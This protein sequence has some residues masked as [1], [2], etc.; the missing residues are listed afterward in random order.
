[1]LDDDVQNRDDEVLNFAFDFKGF[2][3]KLLEYWKVIILCVLLGLLLAYLI[4][5]RKQNVY[6]LSSLISIENNKSPFS[7][8]GTSISFNWGGVSGKVGQIITSFKTRTHNELVVDSLKFYMEYLQE[9]K[10][11]KI[12]VYKK[13][14]FVFQPN[15]S[16]PQLL[17]NV[18]G[19]RFLK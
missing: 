9:G 17:N 12:D 2:F 5:A 8:G 14:P 3:N 6:S 4:N 19:I 16:A 18:I 1:M 15:L 11:Q 13:A 7:T 10:Y